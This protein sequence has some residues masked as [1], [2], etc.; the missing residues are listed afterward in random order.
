MHLWLPHD[1]LLKADKMT[2]A[3]SLELRVPFLDKEVWNLAKS[4]ESEYCIKGEESKRAFRMAAMKNIPSDWGKRKKD[5]L[6]CSIACMAAR[7]SVLCKSEN[8]V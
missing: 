6:S 2:M 5:G 4:L 1:I 8:D 3:H 7:R